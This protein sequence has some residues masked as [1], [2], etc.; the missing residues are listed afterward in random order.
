MG[1]L[2]SGLACMPCSA[3]LAPGTFCNIHAAQCGAAAHAWRRCGA[4]VAVRSAPR[5]ERRRRSVL[6]RAAA[7]RRLTRR[8][9]ARA[10][11]LQDVCFWCG[12]IVLSSGL[13]CAGVRSKGSAMVAFRRK[14]SL[15]YAE[16]ASR[17]NITTV[18]ALVGCAPIPL[19]RHVARISPVWPL[20]SPER[21]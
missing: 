8:A 18:A 3:A 4:R 19:S 20:A 14:G 7:G 1:K 11:R 12:Q 17:C 9:G 6:C 10:A 5:A 2:R 21:C 15:S 13:R 16:V